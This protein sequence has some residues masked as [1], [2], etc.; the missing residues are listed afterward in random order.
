MSDLVG[1]CSYHESLVLSRKPFQA[2]K[3]PVLY[4]VTYEP[5]NA[6]VTMFTYLCLVSHSEHIKENTHGCLQVGERLRHDNVEHRMGPTA[7]TVHVGRS[8]GP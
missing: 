8:N 3:S 5:Q 7:F 6:A 4:M 2:H 1:S